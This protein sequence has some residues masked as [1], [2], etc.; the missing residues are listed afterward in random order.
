MLEPS[1]FTRT[2][3]EL[4]SLAAAVAADD[5]EALAELVRIAQWLNTELVPATGRAIHEAGYSWAEIAAP[6]GIS[7]QSA[8]ER[9]SR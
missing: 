2:E 8:A 3:R 4:K 1:R 6:L 5:A 7:R 9:F